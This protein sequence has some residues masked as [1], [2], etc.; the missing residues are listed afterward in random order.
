MGETTGSSEN[1]VRCDK[2]LGC[3][4][5]T[6]LVAHEYLERRSPCLPLNHF[7]T[8][9]LVVNVAQRL[10]MLPFPIS[11]VRS[12]LVAGRIPGSAHD[13]AKSDC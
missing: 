12:G 8:H 1:Q 11:G 2:S 7:R 9:T 10:G 6:P 13:A 4:S 3:I 5:P